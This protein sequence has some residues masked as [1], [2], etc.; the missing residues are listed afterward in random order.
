[1]TTPNQTGTAPWHDHR[2]HRRAHEDPVGGRVEDLA[3]VETWCQ[4]RAT[5]P[6]TQSVA[7]E[8]RQE[9]GRGRLVVGTEE[10]P[11]EDRDAGQ[12]ERR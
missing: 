4:R 11:D 12:A 5:K 9:D 1:M 8:H 2:D 7:P 6:S 3:E 10:Q